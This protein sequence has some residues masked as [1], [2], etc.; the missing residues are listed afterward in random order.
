MQRGLTGGVSLLVPKL[1]LGNPLWRKALLCET[2]GNPGGDILVAKRSLA[3]IC[4]PKQELG[5]EMTISSHHNCKVR[6]AHPP[7]YN[8]PADR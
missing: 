8:P 5:D 4:V 6:I 2:A 7:L 1:L 3:P